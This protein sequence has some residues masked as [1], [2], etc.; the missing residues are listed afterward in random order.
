MFKQKKKNV[1][2][3]QEMRIIKGSNS[4]LISQFKGNGG[5]RSTVHT[6]EIKSSLQKESI[7]KNW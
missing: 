5:P 6:I 7:S 1:I 3:D 4:Y 2:C